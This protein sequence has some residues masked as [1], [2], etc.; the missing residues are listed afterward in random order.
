MIYF[1]GTENRRYLVRAHPRLNG[2]DYL[3]VVSDG[4]DKDNW[5]R[6]LNVFFVKTPGNQTTPGLLDAL[7][8]NRFVVRITGG[9]RVT[10]ITV[11][12]AVLRAEG[13]RV[14]LEVHVTPRG[15][16]STYTLSIL[17]RAGDAPLGGLDPQLA[18][19]DF[20][21]KVDCPSDFDCRETNLRPCPP[22]QTPDIDYLTKDYTGFR[23]LV[24]DR[25]S[26]LMPGWQEGNPADM[27]IALVELLAYVGDHLSYRQDAIATEA[28]LGTARQRVSVRRH[29][30][31]LDYPMH[32]GCNARAW[33][34]VRLKPVAPAEGV[35]LPRLVSLETD[36]EQCNANEPPIVKTERT[37]IRTRFSTHMAPQTVIP[38][39]EFTKMVGV[40][41]QEVFEPMADAICYAAHNEMLFYT[42][43]ETECRLPMGATKAALKGAFPHLKV[44]DVLIF[45]ERISPA[46][47]S[48][49]DADP[50]R[51]WAVRLTKAQ[52]G[53]DPLLTDGNVPQPFTEIEWCAGDALPFPF[54]IANAGRTDISAALG[55]I[56]PVDHGMT[57]MQPEFL[58][59]MPKTN[60]VLTPVSAQ[61]GCSCDNQTPQQTPPRFRPRLSQRPLTQ[62]AS[63]PCMRITD[64]GETCAVFDPLS[65]ASSLF[66]WEMKR[67][68]PA[69]CLGDSSGKLW[70]PQR[71]LLG[72]AA[73]AQ[74]F[75]VEVEND[76]KAAIRFGDD[77]YGMRP[78]ELTQFWALYRVGNG[79][80]GNIGAESI[81]LIACEEHA[82]VWIESV[83]NPLPAYGGREP[84]TI[85]EVQENA[86]AALRVNQRA[87]TA[88]DYAVFAGKHPEVQRAAAVIRWTGSWNT[89]YLAVDR[90]G[91]KPIDEAFEQRL[92]DYLEPYRMAGHD[93]EIDGPHFVPLSLAMT[94]HVK[95]EFHRSDVLMDIY[96]VFSN[97]VRAN[98][99]KDFFHPD[100]FS[101]GD[102]LYCSKIYEAAQSVVGVDYVTID[103]LTRLGAPENSV[104][105]CKLE[106]DR[107][108]ILRLD[109]DP[110]FPDRG[111][112]TITPMGGR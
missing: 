3:K 88:E 76:G 20:R 5:Q 69:C 80:R 99:K 81:A 7:K 54:C 32:D 85:E 62:A 95:P 102:P 22:E 38:I 45:V 52:V 48:R 25:I 96:D 13:N 26:A 23:R 105:P 47:L 42:W 4:L 53:E 61:S 60:P 89:I 49:A 10:G 46:T 63:L 75:V 72:S 58:G 67:V 2:I 74:E 65:P 71:D 86:P 9:E 93:L 106:F 29:A 18:S 68:Q 109:N 104:P 44:G 43:G 19:I 36:E 78:A 34:Q 110:N 21:F 103:S 77:E 82:A 50:E 79:T 64:D 28:Y 57:I 30:R 27:G 14:W 16:Y 83:T 55:N 107:L 70:L 17:Q 35:L 108:E 39:N 33:V 1:C 59:V 87:V 56:V 51:R 91:G 41:Q 100:N 90:I 6:K 111:K 11:D 66:T 15:D 24:L 31:L 92:R 73:C 12:A 97:R 94:V 40:F 8:N 84:E 98:G 101:F 112:L 37:T